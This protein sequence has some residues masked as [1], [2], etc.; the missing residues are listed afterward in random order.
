MKIINRLCYLLIILAF[1]FSSNVFAS[2]DTSHDEVIFEI[3]D[4]YEQVR[5]GITNQTIYMIL[6]EN[7]VENF[8]LKMSHNYKNEMIL[9]EE[10]GGNFIPSNHSYLSGNKVSIPIDEISGIAFKNGKID[11]SYSTYQ[12]IYFEEIIS[13]NGE[14]ALQNFYVEDL[15]RFYQEFSKFKSSTAP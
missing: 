15:E 2:F 8:N 13:T 12:D 3:I 11:F 9:F 7:V 1:A 6:S 5:L 4:K 10:T 14:H